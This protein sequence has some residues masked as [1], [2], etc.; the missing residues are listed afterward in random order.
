MCSTLRMHLLF[1]IT[2]EISDASD[3]EITTCSLATSA[4]PQVMNEQRL[5]MYRAR[6][7]ILYKEATDLKALAFDYADKT[8]AEIVEG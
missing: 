7:D 4:C 5:S 2:S 1:A 6:D 8:S 3:L